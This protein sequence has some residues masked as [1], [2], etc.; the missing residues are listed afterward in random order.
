MMQDVNVLSTHAHAY[1]RCG[2]CTSQYISD[3][4][5]KMYKY[6]YKEMAIYSKRRHALNTI[7]LKNIFFIVL[8]FTIAYQTPDMLAICHWCLL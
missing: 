7:V 4:V 1:F 3:I 8:S 6:K 5:N 2:N